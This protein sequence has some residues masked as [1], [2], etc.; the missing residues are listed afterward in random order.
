MSLLA[1]AEAQARIAALGTPMPIETVPLVAAAGRWAA[2]DIT[3]IRTQ[4]AANLSAMDGY[5]LRFGELPGPWRVV[6]ESAAGGGLGRALEPGEAAR[7]FTGAPMP[8]GADTVMM[9]EE[10]GRNGDKL[11]LTGEGPPGKGAHVRRRGSDFTSG[12]ALIRAGDRM[13]P[14]RVALAAIGGYGEVVVRRRP[15]IALLSTGDE[16]VAAGQPTAGVSL[17]A[18]NAPML[19]ALLAGLPVIVEDRG[20]VPDRLDALV[21]AFRAAADCDVIVTTGGASV[22]DHDLVRPALLAAGATLDFWRVAMKPGKPLMA[23]RLG[24]TVV[25]GLPGNP[26]SAFVTASLFL[27]PLIATILGAADPLPPIRPAPLAA[28]LPATGVRAEYLR[29]HWHSGAVLPLD[30]QDSAALAM[31]AA[32][33][34]LIV[35]PPHAPAAAA[36]EIVNIVPL[37]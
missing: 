8:D 3:A 26:V 30:G 28:P 35:R 5:A 31:L 29:G 7:I 2:E 18:S 27:Q 22:G 33:E 24:R 32:A 20:I 4:P 9:Q 21:E 12:A 14:A 17:P 19:A 25:I 1:V 10:A 13:T 34:L 15:R 11:T 23:G 36:G 16:L 6:G 37:A